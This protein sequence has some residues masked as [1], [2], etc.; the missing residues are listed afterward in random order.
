MSWSFTSREKVHVRSAVG[1]LKEPL[2]LVS[3]SGMKKG[4]QQEY[5]WPVLICCEGGLLGEPWLELNI[6]AEWVTV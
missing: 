2:V 6:S 3:G 1:L 4:G 5:N